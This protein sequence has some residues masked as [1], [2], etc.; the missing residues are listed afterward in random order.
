MSWFEDDLRTANLSSFN[1]KTSYF[2]FPI[3]FVF[4]FH[5]G[6]AKTGPDPCTYT[7]VQ[8]GNFSDLDYFGVARF[9]SD[10]YRGFVY[11]W[12]S[13]HGSPEILN[14][15][16]NP[17]AELVAT[18]DGVP[19]TFAGEGIFQSITFTEGKTY[20]MR[21]RVASDQV[22]GGSLNIYLTNGLAAGG[23]N[24][25]TGAQPSPDLQQVYYELSQ[26]LGTTTA[27]PWQLV[28]IHFVADDDFS[29]LW[30]T[31]AIQ[32]PV[33]GTSS[34]IFVDNVCVA[35][36]NCSAPNPVQALYTLSCDYNGGSNQIFNINV[37]S[38]TSG[39]Y[40][41]STDESCDEAN[42]NLS[43]FN[44]PAID[45][46]PGGNGYTFSVPYVV[47]QEYVLELRDP[48]GCPQ[49][50]LITVEPLAEIDI[51]HL[52][53][54]LC[55]ENAVIEVPA[56]VQAYNIQIYEQQ[57]NGNPTFLC[58]FTD[59]THPAPA[60]INLLDDCAGISCD[61]GKEFSID[62]IAYDQCTNLFEDESLFAL[63]CMPE[64]VV[65]VS[66]NPLCDGDVATFTITQPTTGTAAWYLNGVFQQN[67]S[68]FT[69]VILASDEV[70]LDYVTLDGCAI[71]DQKVLYA[72]SNC[73]PT[74]D[75]L[76]DFLDDGT[77][78]FFIDKS[79][80][81][82]TDLVISWHWDFG[83][84]NTSTL[85]HP[86]HVYPQANA[87]YTVTL[88]IGTDNGC[89]ATHTRQVAVRRNSHSRRLSQQADAFG[90][91][92]NPASEL[93]TL[94]YPAGL[95][96]EAQLI[97]LTGR[98]LVQAKLAEGQE[99]IGFATGAFANGIYFLRI[100]REDQTIFRQKVVI[101]H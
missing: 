36:V 2:F 20:R 94:R 69:S 7:L 68:S 30:L 83:D 95:A 92:P 57:P 64:P 46:A 72:I 87:I 22:A 37:T 12:Q 75:A 50:D 77:N 82:N 74:C 91:F 6:Y 78:H 18:Y 51:S 28:D 49:R 85:S 66:P 24:S 88:T 15:S 25:G 54:S 39:F 56:T 59:V 23:Q 43:C 5:F 13:S 48:D 80:T 29:A 38:G 41:Y 53:G 33:Y 8:N 14:A 11:D 9:E 63:N 101:Q 100:K 44:F 60:T 89:S 45:Q 61:Q 70:T 86:V 71:F 31:N 62:V 10:F 98:V 26:N 67:G 65:S 58:E 34:R 21:L 81:V 79:P 47:G 4:L 76:F 17:Y 32:S 27:S 73:E 16:N 42:I 19:A 84:G 90:L 55:T 1:M 52:S 40:L 97:D 35:E 96:G 3:L 99:S 93:V